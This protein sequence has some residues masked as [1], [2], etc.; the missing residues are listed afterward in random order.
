[1]TL[2]SNS[3][4]RARPLLGTLVE[5]SV[6]GDPRL[7]PTAVEAAFKAIDR[8]HRLMSFHSPDSDVSRLN[9]HARRR[10]VT[11]D[12]QTW[13]VLAHAR[14][15]SEASHG[16]FDVTIAP[17]LVE[18]GH[19][20]H[21][22][23]SHC[24]AVQ[25]GYR[26]IELQ[27]EGGVRFLE[28]ALIDLGGIAKGYAVDC[29]C[30]ALELHGVSDYV[31]N[32]GGDLRVGR[33]PEIVHVRH[34]RRPTA[35]IP[36]AS[37]EQA[38]V[39]TSGIY[40]SSQHQMGALIHSIITPVTGQSARTCDSVSVIAPDCMTA[41]ALTKVVAV[42]ADQAFPIL[43]H[44]GAEAC[45]LSKGGRWRHLPALKRSSTRNNRRGVSATT[46]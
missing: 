46:H 30:A 27:P 2:H 19:L 4:R 7:L 42:L 23:A 9:R 13:R 37:V 35:I 20:P 25:G 36:L 44:F 22:A 41:D 6:A 45:L 1:M 24:T 34:P 43:A 5:V 28:P 26:R 33:T 10:V 38:A 32:A 17:R 21:C 14:T 31:V 40:F 15:I 3:L 12:P 18:S 11:V 29:A 39:A 16:V 8:V